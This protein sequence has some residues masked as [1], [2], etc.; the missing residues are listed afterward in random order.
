MRPLG[1]SNP[2]PPHYKC[3]A[4][5]NVLSG[6]MR[7]YYSTYYINILFLSSF[8]IKLFISKLT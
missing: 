1:D 5:P 7:A 2:L 3:G 8:L 4:Q 6:L